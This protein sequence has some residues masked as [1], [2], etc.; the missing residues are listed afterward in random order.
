MD[1]SAIEQINE[2]NQALGSDLDNLNNLLS[3]LEIALCKLKLEAEW[4]F[5]SKGV[6]KE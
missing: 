4:A 3:K 2:L 6:E 1:K 5:P